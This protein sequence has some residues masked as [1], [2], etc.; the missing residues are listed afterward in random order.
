MQ[1]VL[2]GAIAQRK[3]ITWTIGSAALVALALAMLGLYSVIAYTVAQQTREIGVRMA[4][5]AEPPMIGRWVLSRGVKLVAIG[6][7]LGIGGSFLVGQLLGS[8]VYGVSSWDPLTY[9]A[10]VLLLGT[11]ALLACWLPARRAARVDPLVALRAE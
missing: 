1:G 6:I 10:V 7:V 8:L 4:I 5:G 2:N 9:G 11:I 3:L